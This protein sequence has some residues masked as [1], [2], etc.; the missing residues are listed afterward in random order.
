MLNYTYGTNGI[1][2]PS[3]TV[4]NLLDKKTIQND[5]EKAKALNPDQIIAFVHWGQQYKDLPSQSQ[6][7]WYAY[8]KSLG[9]NI[10]IGSHPHVVEPMHWEKSSNSLVVYS[11]GNF[12]SNQRTF[13]RDGGALF[14]LTLTKEDGFIEISDAKYLLTWVHKRTFENGIDYYVLPV[15]E[16]EYREAYFEKGSDLKKMKSYAKHARQLLNA[17][18]ENIQE[19]KPFGKQLYCLALSLL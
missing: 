4:V 12:V 13:P 19:Q 14:E 5:V 8:F 11:L 10:V 3:G 7:N 18:N 6:K 2:I 1:P 15:E 16:F 9:V 17:H